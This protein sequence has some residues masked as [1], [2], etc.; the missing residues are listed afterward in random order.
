[1]FPRGFIFRVVITLDL[2]ELSSLV[3]CDSVLSIENLVG[4]CLLCQIR[5]HWDG[6][7][8]N[9]ISWRLQTSF[10]LGNMKHIVNF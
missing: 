4:I 10:E 5:I 3:A 1:M 6:V 9:N 2:V 8:D 7:L